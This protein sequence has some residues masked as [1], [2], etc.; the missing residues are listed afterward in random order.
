MVQVYLVVA[1]IVATAIFAATAAVH[2]RESS[3]NGTIAIIAGALW[4]ALLLGLLELSLVV[5]V[6]R[7]FRTATARPVMLSSAPQS[8]WR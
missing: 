3:H 1:I 2:P 7:P 6:S 4:P 5:A 8:P